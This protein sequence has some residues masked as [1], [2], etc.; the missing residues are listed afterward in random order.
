MILNMIY[1]S[2][3]VQTPVGNF[4]YLILALQYWSKIRWLQQEVFS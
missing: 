1:F 2:S 3:E 4:N